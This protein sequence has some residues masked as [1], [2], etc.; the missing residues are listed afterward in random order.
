MAIDSTKKIPL[1]PPGVM[2]PSVQD[3]EPLIVDDEYLIRETFGQ[4]PK[5]GCELLFRKYYTNLCNHAIRFVHS[6]EV[7]EDIVSEV[8][9]AFWQ[10]RSF[11]LITSSYRAYLYKS[12]R[13]RSYNHLKWELNRTSPIELVT[14]PFLAQALNPYEALQYSELHQQIERIV[15]EMPPQCRKAYLLKRMEGK[16]LEEIAAELQITPKSVEALIT[17][18]IARLR[19]GLKDSWFICLVYWIQ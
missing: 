8:F 11:E 3:N 5:K 18:A 6:G 1:Q 9:A 15:Q 2:G 4:D 13:N 17:R 19:N 14:T 10:N 16:T 12:V 7:A